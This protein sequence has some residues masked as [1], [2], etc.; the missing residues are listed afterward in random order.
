MA[1]TVS[2]I[3]SADDRVRLAA[4]AGDRSRP[5]KHVQRARIILHS[6]DRLSGV[7]TRK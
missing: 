7:T 6:A 2:I 3:V 5:L 4:I 1:Q